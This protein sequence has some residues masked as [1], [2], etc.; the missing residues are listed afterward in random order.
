M[1]EIAKVR[2]YAGDQGA[3]IDMDHAKLPS[4][5]RPERVHGRDRQGARVRGRPGRRDRHGPREAAERGATRTSTWARSPRCACTRATR[6]PRSTW[7]TR[8][9]R[10]RGDPNEYMGEIA[11][12]RVYAG[13]Q[14]AEIDMDH[15]KL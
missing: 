4:A 9:C 12:V 13:D 10:A 14:G 15:A 11:K 8:S 2:V 6:A 5:G 1:G 7:T 3:E